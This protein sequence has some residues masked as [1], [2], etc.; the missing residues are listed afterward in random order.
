[1]LAK[2]LFGIISTT[3]AVSSVL[4][5]GTPASAQGYTQTNLVS[6]LPGYAAWT[7]PGLVNPWGFTY[8]PTSPFWVSDNGSGLATIYNSAGIPS[9]LIVTVPPPTGSNVV[10]APTGQVFNGSNEFQV[11]KGDPAF[12]IFDTEDGTISA[13]N[14][15]VNLKKAILK[16]DNSRKKAVYKGL[17]IGMINGKSYLYAADFG[18]KKIE[19]YNGSFE[20]VKGHEE[21]HDDS[22][23]VPD[24]FQDSKI[25]DDYAPFN[26]ESANGYLLVAFAQRDHSH[27]NEVDGP[28]RGYVDIFTMRGKL[29]MHLQH[30]DFLN[31]PWGMTVAPQAFG[32]AAGDILVGNFGSG[33]I[34][35][36][37][38]KTG[39]FVGFLSDNFGAWITIPGIW[40]IHF[41]NG[42]SGGSANSLY[43]S[44]GLNDENDGLFG[45][46]TYTP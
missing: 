37:N 15:S 36:F 9:S 31:A 41:G 29:I 26:V 5:Q 24:A 28:G 43:F 1:M 39:K 30:G 16:V 45:S 20:R 17:A 3:I 7:D 32:P 22:P 12:F 19:V 18:R 6:N 44:A 13:W 2:H 11:A 42:H 33:W 10:S 46:L 21:D 34:A 27:F 40:G 38:P 8:S 4:L 14:P 35:C 23:L 25:P